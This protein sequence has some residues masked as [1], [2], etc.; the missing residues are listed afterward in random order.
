MELDFVPKTRN[1]IIRVPRIDAKK[2]SDLMTKAG[3]DFSTSRSTPETAVLFT[4]DQYAAVPFIKCATERAK[5]ELLPVSTAI[6]AS[7]ASTSDAHIKCPPDQELAPFQKASVSYAL[8][9]TNTLVGDQ[10]GL[11]KTP[12]A[13]CYANEIAAKRVLVICPANIRNQWVERIREWTTMRWPFVVYPIL[14]GRHGV[15]PQAHWTVVSY[16][17][18]STEAIGSA[19][20]TC[21]Y[22]LIILDEA[23]YLKTIDSN[24][25]HA[26]FGDHTG[27]YQKQQKDEGGDILG[28]KKLFPA[29][30]TRCGSILALTGTPLPNRPREAYTLARNLCFD[31]IDWMSE[32]KFTSRYNPSARLLGH[33]EDGTEFYYNREE[34]GRAGELQARL[35]ANFMVRHLKRDVQPQLKMPVYNLVRVDETQTVKEAVHAESLLGL[36]ADQFDGNIK[37]DGIWA[38]VRRQ[39]GLAIA[40]QV[41]DYAAMCLDGGD[42]KLVIFAWHIDV[43]NILQSRLEKYGVVR[44]DGSTTSNQRKERLADYINNPRMHIMLGNTLSLGTG[45]DGLQK[46]C[47]HALVAEPDPVPGNNEQAIDRLDRMGQKRTVNADLFVAPKSLLERILARA[48]QKRHNTHAALDA[49][50]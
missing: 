49:R 18:A 28:F 7:W 17:L 27:W 36:D 45:T 16:D 2:I 20:A 6:A 39:L 10:P 3:L 1:Y 34:V 31:S 4:P 25:T 21:T 24:R 14:A 32:A 9:R 37:V 33:R 23:H 13:I 8:G 29:L 11:G 41:A 19:L 35:R 15:H 46:V 5:Q 47:D 44:I 22:D 12:I 26:V 43:L 48:L 50:T 30:A 42:E 38:V 40:P